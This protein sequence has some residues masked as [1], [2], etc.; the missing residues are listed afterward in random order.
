MRGR[1]FVPISS[2]VIKEGILMTTTPLNLWLY[3]IH[4]VFF[5]GFAAFTT[6]MLLIGLLIIFRGGEDAAIG[7]VGLGLLPL[8]IAQW[9]GAKG[10]K[11]GKRYGV[12]ISRI[13]GTIWLIGFPI[14]TALGIYVWRNTGDKWKHG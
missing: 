5:L 3:R 7:L 6:I 9:Y 13:F 12:V 1:F 14:G 11:E 10:A 4:R 8:G 2:K